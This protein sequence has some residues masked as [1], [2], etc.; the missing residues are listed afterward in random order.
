MQTLGLV[1]FAVFGLIFGGIGFYLLVD[2]MRTG[3]L[4]RQKR[5]LAV[6]F[7]AGVFGLIG[8]YIVYL[9]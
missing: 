4:F 8:F 6:A 1:I 9:N 3:E 7:G 2:Y 5:L